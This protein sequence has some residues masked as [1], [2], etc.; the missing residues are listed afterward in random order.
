[1]ST[2]IRIT[3]ASSNKATHPLAAMSDIEE[4]VLGRPIPKPARRTTGKAVAAEKSTNAA[5][6]SEEVKLNNDKRALIIA[7]IAALEKLMRED[8][9]QAENDAAHPP[10]KKRIV[11]VAKSPIKC[12]NLHLLCQ[13]QV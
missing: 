10:A 6:D 4:E 1:M 13:M 12:A 8:E 9:L 11:L 2:N 3:R 7:Q 5:S